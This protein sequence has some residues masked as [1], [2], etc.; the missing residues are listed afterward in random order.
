MKPKRKTFDC[1]EMKRRA[2]EKIM[3]EIGGMTREEELAYWERG[4]E[5]LRR[6]QRTKKTVSPVVQGR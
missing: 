5:E 6:I 3:G 2:A 4:T 1:I